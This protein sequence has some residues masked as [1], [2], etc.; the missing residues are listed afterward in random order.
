MNTILQRD[1]SLPE[2]EYILDIDNSSLEYFNTCARSAEFQLVYKR[3]FS[4]SQATRYGAAIHNYRERAVKGITSAENVRQMHEE[5]AAMPP[6]DA[7]E[8]RTFDH[9]LTAMQHY[10]AFYAQWD[11]SGRKLT[12][13]TFVSSSAPIT[14]LG[15]R[16]PLTTIDVDATLG[17]SR[18]VLLGEDSDEPLY[19]AKVHVYWM[20]R[21]DLLAYW[22]DESEPIVLDYKTTSMLGPTF[23]KDFELSQQVLGYLYAVRQLARNPDT[24]IPSVFQLAQSIVIDVIAGRRPTKTGVQ[25][26][27]VRQHYSYRPDQIEEWRVNVTHLVADFL[28]HLAR[29]FFPMQTRQCV[30]KYGICPFHDVCVLPPDFRMKHLQTAFQ[31]VT[32]NP[33]K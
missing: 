10:D 11:G 5:F 31:P 32:W 13:A 6:L 29:G 22:S 3:G 4:G 16:I 12:P 19:V 14:E 8:W 15:F 26:E 9:A 18:R 20:G 2:N 24:H 25:N 30:G 33:L 17:Y 1:S 23:Y 28:S 7:D 21:I 27:F